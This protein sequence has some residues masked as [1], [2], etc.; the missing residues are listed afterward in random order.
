MKSLLVL[1]QA[2]A[3]VPEPIHIEESKV[4]VFH[5]EQPV[6]VEQPVVEEKPYVEESVPNEGYTQPPTYPK[7]SKPVVNVDVD[8]V[9]VNEKPETDEDFFDDFFGSEDE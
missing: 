6:H 5:E 9:V 2:T 1:I 3:V 8:S 4:E 7:V